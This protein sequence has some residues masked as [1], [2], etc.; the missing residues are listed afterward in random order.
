MTFRS[1]TFHAESADIAL[2]NTVKVLV[3]VG[4][5]FIVGMSLWTVDTPDVST[6]RHSEIGSEQSIEDWHGNVRRSTF[7]R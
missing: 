7:G 6:E 3:L 5:G 1:E 2:R 4:I